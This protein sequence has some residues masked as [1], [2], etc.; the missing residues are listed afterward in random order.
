MKIPGVKSDSI[1]YDIRLL[2]PVLILVGVGIVMVYSASSAMALKKFGADSYFLK[3]QSLFALVGIVALVV[4]RHTPYR[5]FKPLA[6][7]IVLFAIG[8]LVSIKI[9]GIGYSAGGAERWIRFAGLSFQPSE[10][11]RFAMIIYLAYSMSK[12]QDKIQILSIGFIPHVFVMLLFAGL[13]KNQVG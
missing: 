10:F 1:Q 2:F 4:L 9:P 12:K 13:M 6:Y 5:I 11:A 3:K 8:L 7:L